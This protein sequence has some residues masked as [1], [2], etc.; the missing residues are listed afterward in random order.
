[1]DLNTL[2]AVV[3]VAVVETPLKGEICRFLMFCLPYIDADMEQQSCQTE[4]PYSAMQ[5]S[6]LTTFPGIW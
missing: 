2:E 6:V 5:S 1:M 4:S 3:F